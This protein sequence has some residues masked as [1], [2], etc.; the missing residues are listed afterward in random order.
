MLYQASITAVV[1]L[2][3]ASFERSQINVAVPN[4]LKCRNVHTQVYRKTRL[5]SLQQVCLCKGLYIHKVLLRIARSSNQ[6]PL[7]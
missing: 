4:V 2:N 5:G 7:Q 6:D 3:Y 1:F